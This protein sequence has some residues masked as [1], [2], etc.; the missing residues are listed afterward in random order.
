MT[1]KRILMIFL[2]IAGGYLLFSGLSNFFLSSNDSTKAAV[3][4]KIDKIE[5]DIS[6]VSLTI[7]PEDRDD[8]ETDFE[9]RGKVTVD[10][11]GDTITVNHEREWFAWFSFFNSSQLKVYVP[12][13]FN[14]EMVIDIGS[15]NLD[16][17][18]NSEKNP[19]KLDKLSMDLGSG[20]VKL[21]NLS[22]NEFTH[23]SSSGNVVAD[24][25]YTEESKIDISSGNVKLTD[26]I[27]E[28]KADISSG[29]FDVQI[30]EL[31][32][33]VSIDVSSGNVTL[34][35]PDKSDFTLDGDVGSGNISYD[36]PLTVEEQDDGDIKASH[37]S[38]EH[39]IKIDVSSGNVKIH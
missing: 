10:Q 34:D 16:F 21:N 15:G 1:M 17:S 4:D 27:G 2:I 38:G 9:G 22:V 20:N 37:G 19:Y 26:F 12:E 8:L 23:D 18:G 25:L 31:K 11:S 39:D 24:S 7:I 33:S 29:K 3:T 13:D 14:K 32:N 28:L 36:F 5:F 30:A 6:S 35:L